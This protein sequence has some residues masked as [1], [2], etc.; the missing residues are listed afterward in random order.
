MQH[1]FRARVVK[2][3]G[4][5]YRVT[6]LEDGRALECRIR[7]K[8]RQAGLRSTNP[9]AVGDVVHV[10][11]D[12]SGNALITEVAQRRNYI[13]RRSVNLSKESHIIAANLDQAVII[14]TLS[15]PVTFPVF[16]DR[17][18]V[19]A[20]AFHIPPAVVI[21]KV[22]L[23]EGAAQREALNELEQTYLKA[24]YPVVQCSAHSGT[25]ME[26]LRAL[27]SGKTSLLSGHS[28]VGKSTLLN[29]LQPGL[30]LRTGAVS[31]AH[32]TGQHTTTFAEMH[33]LDSGSFII[34]TPGIRGFGIV[35][36]DPQELAGYFPEMR[37]LLPQCRF[38]NCL[39]LQEPGCAVKAALD[40]GQ[41][42]ESRYLS[43]VNMYHDQN[44]QYR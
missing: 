38:Y 21:N 4:S 5:W 22:D 9:V 1:S 32:G 23:L 33:T 12:D 2:S 14:A 20:E 17:F 25:G 3:T 18:C 29:R 41:L 37:S 44:E 15:A 8:L 43:Y 16:I 35:D 10:E 31:S 30:E 24:G 34:D 40:S 19:A 6:S 39:H 26:A 27:L 7:G 13:V 42:A 28:G 11:Q 36:I